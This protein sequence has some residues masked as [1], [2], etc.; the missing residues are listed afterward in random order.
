MLC[1]SLQ[2]VSTKE[3]NDTIMGLASIVCIAPT[4]GLHHFSP[5]A[6]TFA[7][8]LQQVVDAETAMEPATVERVQ[9]CVGMLVLWG[10]AL[11]ID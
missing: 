10:C 2:I 1:F 8:A 7:S 5:L 9:R 4:I 11:L 6:Y 3:R